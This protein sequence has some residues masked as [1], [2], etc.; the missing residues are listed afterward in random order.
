MKHMLSINKHQAPNTRCSN[1]D[2]ADLICSVALS[3]PVRWARG[4]AILSGHSVLLVLPSQ[5]VENEDQ[6]QMILNGSC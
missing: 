2:R 3:Q 5:Q 1:L 4:Y 6:Q